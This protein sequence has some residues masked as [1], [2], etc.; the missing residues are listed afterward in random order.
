MGQK[1]VALFLSIII[2]YYFTFKI[3]GGLIVK[4]TKPK[5]ILAV[6]GHADRCN[7]FFIQDILNFKCLSRPGV[8]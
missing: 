3:Q 5:Q 1:H 7:A 8:V 6:K 2:L 4:E